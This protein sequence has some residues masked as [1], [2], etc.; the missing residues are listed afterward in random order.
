M[1][2]MI[3]NIDFVCGWFIVNEAPLEPSNRTAE[4]STIKFAGESVVTCEDRNNS[5]KA[6]SPIDRAARFDGRQINDDLNLRQVIRSIY[7][8]NLVTSE[9]TLSKRARASAENFE[10]FEAIGSD[11][12]KNCKP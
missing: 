3:T 9:R 11:S 8:S 6:G 5:S 2:R 10:V 7:C 1:E 12:E 4:L